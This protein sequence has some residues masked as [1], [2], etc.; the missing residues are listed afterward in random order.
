MAFNSL[1]QQLKLQ[2][3]FKQTQN[4]LAK[5]GIAAFLFAISETNRLEPKDNNFVYNED[6][7]AKEMGKSSLKVQTSE[8]VEMKTQKFLIII[9]S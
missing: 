6:Y 8:I 5:D 7:L 1:S 3:Y 9:A 2:T 4:N